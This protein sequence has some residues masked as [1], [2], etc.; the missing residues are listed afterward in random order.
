VVADHAVEPGNDLDTPG[1]TTS[2]GGPITDELI[3]RI[4]RAAAKV[5]H[6]HSV[7]CLSPSLLTGPGEGR[8][9]QVAAGIVLQRPFPEPYLLLPIRPLTTEPVVR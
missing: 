5:C 3:I 2:D 6:C 1:W 9:Q 8:F 4:W 7:L